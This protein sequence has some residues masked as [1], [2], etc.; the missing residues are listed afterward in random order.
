MAD[1]AWM[2]AIRAAILNREPAKAA[3][4]LAHVPAASPR[5]SDAELITGQALWAAYLEA[6]RLPETQQPA[7]ADM[8][9]ML[10]QARTALEDGIGRQRKAID[11][12][13]EVSHR[14]LAAVLSLAQIDLDMGVGEK[15]ARWLDDPKLGPHTLVKAESKA[16]GLGSFRVETLK[17]ALRAYVATQQLDKAEQT[18][19]ALEKAGGVA[20]LTAIYISLGRQLEE[21]LRRIRAEGKREQAAK[22]ARGFQSFLARIS[23]RPAQETTFNSLG[24]V[25]ETLMSLGSAAESGSL[26]PEAEGDYQKA[27]EVYR[28]IIEICRGDEKFA[29]KAGAVTGVQIRLARCLRLLGRFNQSLDLLVEVLTAH[30]ALIDGQREAAYTY[31]AWGERDPEKFL[32]AI[33][34]GHEVERKPRGTMNLIWGWALIA[35]QAQ[36]RDAYQDLFDEAR[37]NMALCRLNYALT[38]P[39]GEKTQLLR[40]AEQD[41]LLIQRLRPEMGGKKW[42]PQ[43]DALLRK[44]Q[45]LLGLSED[46]QG[47]KAAEERL[48]QATE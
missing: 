16:V 33:R 37:Y 14:L 10:A 19:N 11:A 1:E 45:G 8:T 28:R 15:A 48:S 30:E 42:Y 24:W 17:A 40:L 38:R 18:M 47:L 5:R 43:Y 44:I 31:Q 27:A 35:R 22:V 41:I 23:A 39:G 21:S 12:G 46:Q 20:N 9:A 6:M 3:E 36:F 26:S 7:K 32:L 4:Y 34:G 29:P 2:A 13:Q 25:A